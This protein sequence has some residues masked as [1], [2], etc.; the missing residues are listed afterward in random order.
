MKV[1]SSVRCIKYVHILVSDLPDAMDF[2]SP[3]YP[4]RLHGI[5]C[6]VDNTPTAIIPFLTRKEPLGS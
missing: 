5:S 4:R 6:P 2:F 1:S 3:D